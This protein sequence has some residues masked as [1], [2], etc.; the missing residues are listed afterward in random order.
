[1]P[2]YEP[3][4][5]AQLTFSV[6]DETG[7]PAVAALGVQVVDEAVFALVDARPGLLR[8]YFELEDEFAQ[9]SYE[10]RPPLV[11]L[12]S[13]LFSDTAA[14]DPVAAGAAQIRL[15]WPTLRGGRWPDRRADAAATG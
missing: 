2:P 11:D 4:K 7:A 1:M 9:P 14:S 13:L 12:N 10:I 3:G 5:P 6:T 8:T 15:V